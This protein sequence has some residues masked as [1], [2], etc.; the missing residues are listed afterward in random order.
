MP[1]YKTIQIYQNIG[2]DK[3]WITHKPKVFIATSI[4][5]N[6]AMNHTQTQVELAHFLQIGIW[7]NK[8]QLA[9]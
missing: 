8:P 5:N 4:T 1:D 6:V 7:S 3:M 9:A 2:A